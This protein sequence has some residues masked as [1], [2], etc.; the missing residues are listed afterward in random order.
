MVKLAS[1]TP[2]FVLV[3]SVV[4][5]SP[6]QLAHGCLVGVVSVPCKAGASY[7]LMCGVD[8]AVGFAVWCI[9]DGWR[10]GVVVGAEV[11]VGPV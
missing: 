5:W 11:V 10:V 1:H 8:W 9:G 3:Q 7:V 6:V 4:R 2:H